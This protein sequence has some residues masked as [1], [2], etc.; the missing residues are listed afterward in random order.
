MQCCVRGHWI[1][2]NSVQ[3]CVNTH[4]TTLDRKKILRN[5]LPEPRDNIEQEQNLVQCC[6]NILGKTL[7]RSKA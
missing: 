7:H 3:F 1:T 4:G 6:P 2:K 5:V